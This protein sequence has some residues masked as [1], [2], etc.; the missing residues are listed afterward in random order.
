[1]KISE[2]QLPFRVETTSDAVAIIDTEFQRNAYI[3][4][5]GDVDALVNDAAPLWV[6]EFAQQIAEYTAA[7]AS[8]CAKWGCE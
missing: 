6:P 8:D 4:Q 7:K 2:L 3:E 5:Y 1:M